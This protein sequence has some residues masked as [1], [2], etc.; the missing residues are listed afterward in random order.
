MPVNPIS[1]PAPQAWSGG[2]DFSPLA[3]LGNVYRDAQSEAAKSRALAQLGQ[4]ADVDAQTLLRSGVPSLV[5][6]GINMQQKAKE[7]VRSN[8]Y[9]TIQQEAAKRAKD[10]ADQE[11]EDRTNAAKAVGGL[12]GGQ[13]PAAQPSAFP[14]PLP[15]ANPQPV[16]PPG[17]AP[18]VAQGGDETAPTAPAWA[19][20]P[21]AT[22]VAETLTSG[23]PAATAGISREQIGELYAN[24]LTRPLAT[25]FIQNLTAP[26]TWSYHY[27][28]DGRVIATNNKT[29]EVKDVTPPAQPGAATSKIERENTAREQWALQK[30]YDKE[31]A[32][33]YGA[34]G[35]LPGE[36]LKPTE[37]KLVDTYD[38]TAKSGL[39]VLDSLSEMRQLSKTAYEGGLATKRA[40]AASTLGGYAPQ[41]ALDTIRL[42]NLA[43]QNVVQQAKTLFPGRIL[44]SEID[45]MKQIETLPEYPDAVRQQILGQ[46]ETLIKHRVASAQET[47]GAI[48]NKTYF[49]KDYQPTYGRGE[50]PTGS[51]NAPDPLG[52]R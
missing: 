48:R 35:K 32:R 47:A 10:K 5:T 16:L 52:I 19:T 17:A 41:G 9:L 36:E 43:L 37:Q 40:N 6:L 3:N 11:E 21:V 18:V 46:L 13:P 44:K 45:I 51:T 4:G 14:A 28:D 30:G 33:A 24:P 29:Q 15:G 12:L 22:R 49:T 20:A 8:A 23:R 38:A 42:Q 7:D 34:T 31:T 25:A 26:G 1:F 27:G 50:Q 2:V 39:D